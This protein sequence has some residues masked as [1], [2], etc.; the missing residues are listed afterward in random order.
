MIFL[1]PQRTYWLMG[2]FSDACEKPRRHALHSRWRSAASEI[3][4]RHSPQSDALSE[5]QHFCG[6]P[7]PNTQRAHLIRR[8]IRR[9]Q[10]R[11]IPRH[12]QPTFFM[13][14]KGG[15]KGVGDE[16]VPGW[17]LL[18][19]LD[20]EGPG[21]RNVG[22]EGL[23]GSAVRWAWILDTGSSQGISRLTLLW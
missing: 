14:V 20:Q 7:A 2:K 21:G 18:R 5:Q 16:P 13:C 11:T 19:G 10:T 22:Q 1:Q 23:S 9:A 15:I 4:G 12:R 8:N 17:C 6:V 3:D